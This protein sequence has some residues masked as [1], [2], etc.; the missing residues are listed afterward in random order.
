MEGSERCHFWKRTVLK[1]LR[2]I[3]L[4]E[5]GCSDVPT[6]IHDVSRKA[7]FESFCPVGYR[8]VGPTMCNAAITACSKGAQWDMALHL[9]NAMPVRRIAPT[10]ATWRRSMSHE[11]CLVLEWNIPGHDLTSRIRM[12]VLMKVL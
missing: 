4:F 8:Q 2:L 10:A 7:S 1:K 12:R 3:C 11:Q 6:Q 5:F 9:L